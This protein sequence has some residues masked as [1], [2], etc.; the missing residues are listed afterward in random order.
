MKKVLFAFGFMLV[1]LSANA[2]V[3][4]GLKGPKFKNQKAWEKDNNTVS[5]ASE[6]KELIKGPK[7]KNGSKYI[8]LKTKEVGE[9]NNR[10]GMK[11]PKYK[12]TR[13]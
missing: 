8:V 10:K 2:Q 4:K 5:V 11:G 7:A 9:G 13:P 1:V 3:S 6:S 12:N